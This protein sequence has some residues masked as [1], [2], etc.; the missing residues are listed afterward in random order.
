[1]LEIFV[2][3]FSLVTLNTVVS[4]LAYV[5]E[6]IEEKIRDIIEY[7]LEHTPSGQGFYLYSVFP[8]VSRV[9]ETIFQPTQIILGRSYGFSMILFEYNSGKP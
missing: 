1:M 8:N 3:I 2:F 5:I 7:L 4:A 6:G 9:F